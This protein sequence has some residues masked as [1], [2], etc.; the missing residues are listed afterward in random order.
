[1]KGAG[2][3]VSS[4]EWSYDTLVNGIWVE[5]RLVQILI[6]NAVGLVAQSCLTLCDSMDC[7]PPGFSVHRILQ[8]RILEWIAIPFFRGSSWPRDWTQV[9]HIAGWFFTTWA[10]REALCLWNCL[11]SLSPLCPRDSQEQSSVQSFSQVRLFAAPWTTAHQTSLSI[12]SFW[13]LLILMSIE[14]VMPPKAAK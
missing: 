3:V 13:N 12:A 11:N 9:S 14:S 5:D 6:Q 10:T 4:S 7:S 8:A 1:M 2:H